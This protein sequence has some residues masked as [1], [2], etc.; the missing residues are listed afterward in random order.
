[1]YLPWSEHVR[2]RRSCNVNSSSSLFCTNLSKSGPGT[3]TS[4]CLTPSSIDTFGFPPSNTYISF[5]VQNQ[6]FNKLILCRGSPQYKAPPTQPIQLSICWSPWMR[7][8]HVFTTL[9]LQQLLPFIRIIVPVQK[10]IRIFWKKVQF[11]FTPHL[12]EP[13]L[14][15]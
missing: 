10:Q 12:V 7:R 9:G 13:G 3:F 15:N 6:N 8:M 11:P 5:S 1:M 2:V 14:T 4:T